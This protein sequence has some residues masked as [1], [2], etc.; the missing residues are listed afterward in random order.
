MDKRIYLKGTPTDQRWNS[1]NLTKNIIALAETAQIYKI[2][3]VT[4]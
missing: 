3:T 4:E 2:S 1:W